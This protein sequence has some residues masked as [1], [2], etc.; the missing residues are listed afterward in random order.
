METGCV[1][2]LKVLSILKLLPAA[3]KLGQG[4]VFT[5]VCDSAH[6]GGSASVHA[7]IPH[8]TR[9]DTPREQTS[10]WEQTPPGA[11]THQ[12]QTPPRA[13]TLQEQTPPQSRHPLG[14]DTPK[15]DPPRANIHPLEQTPPRSRHSPPG[16]QTPPKPPSRKADYGIRSTSGRYASYWNAFLFSIVFM[17]ELWMSSKFETFCLHR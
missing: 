4:N 14:A 5:G 6:G 11:D 1:S 8:P 9:A 3:T 15:T 16:K 10:P 2:R 13:D 7:G 12:E 17:F